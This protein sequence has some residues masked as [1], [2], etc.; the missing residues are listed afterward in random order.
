MHTT[1][2]ASYPLGMF[3]LIKGIGMMFVVVFHTLSFADVS[4]WIVDAVWALGYMMACFFSVSGFQFRPGPMKQITKRCAKTYLPMYFR[5]AAAVLLFML[6][7][8]RVSLLSYLVGFSLGKF[9]PRMF[10]GFYLGGI[11]LGWFVLSLLWGSI[12]LNLVLKIKNGWLRTLCVLALSALRYVLDTEY[13]DY[14]CLYRAFEALPAMYVG[15][16]VYAW[17]LLG[18]S[19]S[20][21][22]RYLPY[23]LAVL[24]IPAIYVES[25]AWWMNIIWS[26]GDIVWGYAAICFSRDTVRKSGFLLELIR[27]IGRY[28][29]WIITVHGMEMICFEWDKITAKFSFIPNENLKFFVMVAVRVAVIYVGC[30][31]LAQIDKLEKQWKRKRRSRKRAQKRATA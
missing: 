15:Y 23:A 7:R 27:K 25:D 14:F 19:E 22:K 30:V 6:L 11:G 10:D 1:K 24:M 18:A 5:L 3:D 13:T 28:T 26:L 2:S 29:P 21:W 17:N 4:H 8:R 31:I 20:G 9:Y 12:L 16:C